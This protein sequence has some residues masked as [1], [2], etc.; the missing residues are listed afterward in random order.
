M[1]SRKLDGVK[2]SI[3]RGHLREQGIEESAYIANGFL[4]RAGLALFN[5]IVSTEGD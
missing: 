5:T 3:L 2:V 1:D 4:T